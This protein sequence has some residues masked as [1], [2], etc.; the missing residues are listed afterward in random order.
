[1]AQ[2]ELVYY[3]DQ[4]FIYLT[5]QTTLTTKTTLTTLTTLTTQTIL[6]PKPPKQR[7]P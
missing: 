3:C 6:T 4:T 7:Q 2:E 5:T 1:M